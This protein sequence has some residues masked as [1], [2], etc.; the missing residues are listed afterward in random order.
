MTASFDD[1]RAELNDFSLL[2][3]FGRNDI[4]QG[5]SISETKKT[6]ATLE[7]QGTENC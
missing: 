6:L 4:K 3:Y 1:I 7:V 5:I 2:T